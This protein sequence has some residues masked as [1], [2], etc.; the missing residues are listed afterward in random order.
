LEHAHKSGIVHRDV[1][2]SN[3]LLPTSNFHDAVLAD[4]G[5]FGTLNVATGQTV[6]SGEMFGTP[7]YM[8]P[9]QLRGEPQS[10]ATDFYGLGMLLYQ[11]V[12]AKTPFDAAS[13]PSL[14]YRTMT[15]PVSFPSMPVI[16]PQLQL[17]ISRCLEKTPGQ[18]PTSPLADLRRLEA[19]LASEED[20]VF[21]SP[22]VES[23]EKLSTKRAD[24]TIAVRSEGLSPGIVRWRRFAM[25]SGVL[26]IAMTLA[27][28]KGSPIVRQ[29]T[30]G[31]AF[32]IGG[33]FLGMSAQ[34]WLHTRRDA[35]SAEAA[36]ILTGTRD[37]D[38]LTQSLAI[39]VDQ[40]LLR[41]K[42]LDEKILGT[43]LA[44]MVDEVRQARGFDDRHRALT[45]SVDFLEKLMTRLTPWYVKYEKLIAVVVTL[46]GVVP[47]LLTIANALWRH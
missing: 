34:R 8:S 19:L 20:H 41:C 45:A 28:L 2:P 30:G 10:A 3:V 1:K 39:C 38:V 13:V 47:G 46:I 16:S 12:Y 44:I 27:V 40:I 18:R 43:S 4:F 29:T 23:A 17:F 7:V 6:T 15:E 37:R 24:R 22:G 25:M 36:Q 32:V 26:A 14:F 31:L 5:L 35:V 9:E 21:A 11:M 33:V 42:D